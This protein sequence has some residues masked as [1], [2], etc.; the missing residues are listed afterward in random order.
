MPHASP[1]KL[2]ITLEFLTPAV[3]GSSR[4]RQCDPYMPLRPASLRGLWRTWF[5]AIAGSLLWV[6]PGASGRQDTVKALLKAESR[7]FG[8]TKHRSR[9][10]LLPPRDV[11]ARRF[12]SIPP[13]TSGLRYL[14]Y[15]LFEDPSRR[16][17]ECI[18]ADTRATLTCLLRSKD[19]DRAD[20]RAL[21][22][23][24]WIWAAIGGL[25]GR[26]RRGFGSVR[27]AELK[28]D[29]DLIAPWNKLSTLRDT[30]EDYLAALRDGIGQAQDAL[31]AF[32]KA[33]EIGARQLSSSATA[34]HEAVR[35]LDG[36]A[37]TRALR[38]TYARSLDALDHAGLL[39]RDF[40]SSLERGK[41]RE[42]PLPDYFEVKSSLS[43]PF[44]PPRHVDRAAFGLPLPFFFRSLNGKKTRFVPRPDPKL[45]IDA[46]ESPDR[47]ASPLFFRVF[48]LAG[49]KYGVA[50]LNLAGKHNAPPLQGCVPVAAAPK[51]AR[52]PR[53][54]RQTTPPSSRIIQDFIKWA[55]AQP[56]PS[57]SPQRSRR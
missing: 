7:L 23:T 51:D 20:L 27:I 3:L 32:L 25:G 44:D 22:A 42:P 54:Q 24:L 5:R 39:F 6:E 36:L 48:K 14:G 34:P 41:R 57:T 9:L 35:N 17:P 56:P 53:N 33:E 40:R 46:S 30:P 16:P 55:I 10:V 28:A 13:P 31:L 21:C 50:L 26:S 15:G 1:I 18:P 43:H 19:P 12:D 52:P 2:D 29:G 47:L 11:T 37:E 38:H 4:P 8:D 45:T 49:G